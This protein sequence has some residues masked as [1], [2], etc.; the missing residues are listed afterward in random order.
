[1][2]FDVNRLA[3]LAGLPGSSSDM[4]TEA[5]NRSQH[6]DPGKPDDVEYRWGKNQLAETGA[7]DDGESKGDKG[8]DPDDPEARDYEHGGDRKG[9]ESKTRPGEKDDEGD[10]ELGELANVVLE[11]DENMLRREIMRM[12][13]DRRLQETRQSKHNLQEAELRRA[14]R[15]EIR[16]ILDDLDLNINST[17]VYGNKKPKNSGKGRINM[18]FGGIGFKQG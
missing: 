17:W 13:K 10:E 18:G 8:K 6:D 7:G 2:H 4:L 11:I 12:R 5:G 3:Q 15:S 16:H 1:M 9:D 14:V